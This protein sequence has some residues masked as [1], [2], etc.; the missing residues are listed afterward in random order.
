MPAVRAAR[1]MA[2]TDVELTLEVNCPWVLYEA[3]AKAEELK[4]IHLK[5][6][7]E[8]L[9]PPENY[10]G[11]AQLRKS[12]GIPIA[13]RENASPLIDFERLL[14]VGGQLTFYNRA[15]RKWAA[16]ANCERFFLSQMCVMSP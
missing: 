16:S 7:E 9:W 10:D 15:L 8:P 13:A 14:A 4:E 5:W 11:L 1:E 2:G 6:S 3:S 12:C